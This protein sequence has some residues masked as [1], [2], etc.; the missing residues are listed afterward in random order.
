[1]PETRSELIPVDSQDGFYVVSEGWLTADIPFPDASERARLER[2]GY[3]PLTGRVHIDGRARRAVI[4]APP[5]GDDQFFAK[6]EDETSRIGEADLREATSE[7]VERYLSA[8]HVRFG[9][10]EGV[11]PE[12]RA[13]IATGFV[14]PRLKLSSGNRET[15]TWGRLRD[16][17]YL[18][19]SG[20]PGSGKTTLLRQWMIWQA[21]RT[22]RGEDSFLPICL[23]LRGFDTHE[24]VEHALRREAERTDA[25][26]LAQ[27]LREYA[28]RGM[29][30][31]AFDGLDEVAV[32]D[33]DAAIGRLAEFTNQF[34]DCRY[35]VTTR[36]GI[37]V[38]LDVGLL[39]ADILPFDSP[40]LRQFVYYRLHSQGAWKNFATT[41][42]A[43]PALEWI[44]GN[45]LALSL[46]VARYLRREIRPGLVSEI[47]AA[48]VDMFL[49]SWDSSRGIV[50]TRR[51]TMSPAIKRK[52]LASLAD[53]R[54]GADDVHIP[55]LGA[56]EEDQSREAALA[57]LSEHTGLLKKE[58][59]GA[60]TFKD[61]VLRDFFRA[62]LWVTALASKAGDFRSLLRKPL[63]SARTNL[64]TFVAF[65][66]SDVDTQ[67]REVLLKR[68]GPELATAARLTEVISQ[69]LALRKSTLA[70]YAQL[71]A[72]VLA[73][74]MRTAKVTNAYHH[75]HFV[76]CFSVTMPTE[77]SIADSDLETLVAALHRSRD[78]VGAEAIR[79][80]I[81]NDGHESGLQTIEQ[82]LG[83]DGELHM[84][85]T[86]DRMTWTVADILPNVPSGPDQ[87][88]R[89]SDVFH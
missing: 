81:Q 89:R 83:A 80:L 51:A 39:H 8:L 59:G 79:T 74:P 20:A 48:V 47:V 3:T 41:V 60:W 22:R 34:P 64:A 58:A 36:P 17:N 9:R 1:M 62:T 82:L 19:V 5:G 27:S 56:M 78:G 69:G 85:R 4:L 66:S 2:R 84:E 55:I 37:Q 71:V 13:E 88:Q 42:E 23:P 12:Q 7:E 43:E 28:V 53:Q 76:F 14:E 32:E 50:R 54:P 25:P 29:L 35:L 18:L 57:M 45:P 40:R 33:R 11:L 49:D 67:I 87:P 68:T 24:T 73:E 10:S 52:L 30:A 75:S 6:L 16:N 46:L 31:I 44:V 38:D 15:V 77:L 86:G 61:S 70:S 63:S 72:D 21:D 26:W 65:M